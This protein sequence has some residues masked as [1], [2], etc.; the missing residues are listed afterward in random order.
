ML[1]GHLG[2]SRSQW[3]LH[4]QRHT[5]RLNLSRRI[6][7]RISRSN[8]RRSRRSR[9]HRSPES[10]HNLT[11][12]SKRTI[13]KCLLTGNLHRPFTQLSHQRNHHTSQQTRLAHMKIL[14]QRTKARRYTLDNQLTTLPLNLS[15]KL[16][17]H[18]DCS[19]TITAWSISPQMRNAISKS[20][21]NDST[22]SKT[23]RSRHRKSRSRRYKSIITIHSRLHILR[24]HLTRSRSLSLRKRSIC[25]WSTTSQTLDTRSTASLAHAE[26]NKIGISRLIKRHNPLDILRTMSDSHHLHK[27]STMIEALLN[28]SLERLH[29]IRTLEIMVRTNEHSATLMRHITHP[30][31]HL[32]R[33]L[34]LHIHIPRASLD[35]L[36]KPLLSDLRSLDLPTL[37]SQALI[38]KRRLRS[39]K[40]SQTT[41]SH[42]RHIRSKTLLNILKRQIATIQTNLR[43][44]TALKRLSDLRKILI[45]YGSTN[46]NSKT[47]FHGHK[48]KN[49]IYSQIHNLHLANSH[50]KHKMH[51]TLLSL[52]ILTHSLSHMRQLERTTDRQAT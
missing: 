48:S 8:C 43:H 37:R 15:T 21:S 28:D 9:S 31:G 10:L 36:A 46:H 19:L 26:R 50:R 32:L 5:H 38:L 29:R 51:L 41:C 12:T 6:D 34:N 27:I 24:S 13:Q 2:A 11:R 3:S 25:I 49:L 30:L 7:R 18:L 52:L 20:R 23:L 40:I 14:L 4:S 47:L 45:L 17:R 42:E 44:L 35:S 39:H 1:T 22:L 16:L 33:S